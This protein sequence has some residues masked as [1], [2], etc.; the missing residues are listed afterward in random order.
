MCPLH[1][2]CIFESALVLAR[3]SATLA[4]GVE[5]EQN[6]P[7]PFGLGEPAGFMPPGAKRVVAMLLAISP[8][9][10]LSASP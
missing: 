8:L 3:V 10:Q 7:R 2:L 1:C 6:I 9:P 4:A 5:F